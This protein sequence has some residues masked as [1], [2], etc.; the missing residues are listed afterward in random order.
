M[1]GAIPGL[2]GPGSIKKESRLSKPVSNITHG[3]CIS[4]CLQDSAWVE[5][6]PWLPSVDCDSGYM[7]QTNPFLPKLLL[8]RCF[9]AML[10]QLRPVGQMHSKVGYIIFLMQVEIRVHSK[11]TD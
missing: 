5:F 7:S 1:G 6:L 2:V 8:V 9:I 10:T 4:S 3:L 11:K